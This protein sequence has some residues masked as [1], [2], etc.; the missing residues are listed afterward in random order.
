MP[1]KTMVVAAVIVDSLN[2]PTRMLAA[3]R[4]QPQAIAGRW[5]FPGGKVESGEAELDALHRELREELGVQLRVGD[6]VLGPV[7]G[8]WAITPKHLM[9][10]WFAQVTHG[11]PAPLIEHDQLRWI[12]PAEFFTLDWLDGDVAI[13]EHLLQFFE[14]DRV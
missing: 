12:A 11:E 14:A 13:V 3:R 5:E 8:A 4:S 6:K 1:G 7:A 9:R 10:L 2:K